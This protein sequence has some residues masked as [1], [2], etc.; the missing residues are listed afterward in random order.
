MLVRQQAATL[1]SPVRVGP[2]PPYARVAERNTRQ[3]KDLMSHLGLV[4][5]NPTSCTRICAFSSAGQSIGFLIRESRV[6]IL[7]GVPYA[8]VVEFGRHAGLRNRCRKA[9]GFDSRLV[10]QQM[11]L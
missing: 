10:Y 6:R 8:Q 5:S 7:E 4:G 3:A 9:C 2:E 11:R 1:V